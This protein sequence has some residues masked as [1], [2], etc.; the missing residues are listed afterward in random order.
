[1]ILKKNENLIILKQFATGKVSTEEFW[2]EYKINEKLRN[3]LIQDRKRPKGYNK[4][5]KE[6]GR[7]VL[8]KDYKDHQYFLNPDNLLEKFNINRLDHK[9]ELFII[10]KRY[11]LERHSKIQFYNKDEDFY[12]YLKKML[13]PWLDNLDSQF[14]LE[15]FNSAPKDLNK[16]QK[17]K[18]CKNKIKELFLYLKKP[19]QWIQEA[20]WP[21]INGQPLVFIYQEGAANDG[22]VIYYFTDQNTEEHK[23]V[24]QFA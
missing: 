4:F 1:M 24:V 10:V 17:I 6:L 13:P 7:F 12:V 22:K 3:I 19:P 9:C 15:I 23:T 21:I 11:F 5:S 18:W 20:E 8:V 14:M 2:E 16:E